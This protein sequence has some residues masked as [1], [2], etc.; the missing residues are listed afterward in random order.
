CAFRDY[1]WSFAYW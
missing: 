1:D